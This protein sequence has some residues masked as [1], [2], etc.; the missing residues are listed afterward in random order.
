MKNKFEDMIYH[1]TKPKKEWGVRSWGL[2]QVALALVK[3]AET[4][5]VIDMSSEPETKV[6]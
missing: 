5:D 3:I 2:L 4:A 1:E 6:K